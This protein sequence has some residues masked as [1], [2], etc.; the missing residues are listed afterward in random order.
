MDVSQFTELL[1]RNLDRSRL[2]DDSAFLD[3]LVGFVHAVDFREPAIVALLAFHVGV[4]ALAVALRRAP[5]ASAALFL[6]VCG[7]VL[8]AASLNEWLG[9]RGPAPA[10]LP[11]WKRAGFSQNYFDARGAFAAILFCAPLLLVA[12]GQMLYALSLASSLLIK[13]KRRE[14][15]DARRRAAEAEAKAAPQ[16][17]GAAE[18]AA[19]AAAAA[20]APAAALE[21]ASRPEPAAGADGVRQ[22]REAAAQ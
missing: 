12:L 14:V 8:S 5:N 22:R 7:L 4:A 3:Q 18:A 15:L 19:A 13:V 17:A 2:R 20:A 6:G 11:N 1:S 9:R 21:A 16:A 10:A